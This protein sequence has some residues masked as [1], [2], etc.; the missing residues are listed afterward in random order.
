MFHNFIDANTGTD[1][2]DNMY[3]AQA[4]TYFRGILKYKQ[5]LELEGLT[6]I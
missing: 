2:S 1:I 6:H 4:A 5:C 3:R